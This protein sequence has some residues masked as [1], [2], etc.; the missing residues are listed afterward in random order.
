MWRDPIDWTQAVGY[1]KFSPIERRCL[2]SGR[3][4]SH[5][6]LQYKRA[7]SQPEITV[8]G[9]KGQTGDVQGWGCYDV[10]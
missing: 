10:Y 6:Q 5:P 1:F 7:M 3:Q 2:K 4:G 9:Q 8:R